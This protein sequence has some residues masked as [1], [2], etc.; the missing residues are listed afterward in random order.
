[1]AK[2]QGRDSQGRDA[3]DGVKSRDHVV[4]LQS[5]VIT[6]VARW[7]WWAL[8][9][10]F[11][12]SLALRWLGLGVFPA[13]R[14]T[15]DEYHY[16]WAGLSLLETGRPTSWSYMADEKYQ[17]AQIPWTPHPLVLVR[18]ALDHPPLFSLLC[19]LA[20]R[21]AGAHRVDVQSTGSQSA[22]F[23][24]VDMGRLRHLSLLLYAASFFLLFQCS[25]Y[26]FG[27]QAGLLACVFYGF[28]AHIVFH[29]RLLVTENLTTALMLGNILAVQLFCLGTMSRRWFCVVTVLTTACAML[30]KLVAVSQV[31]VIMGLL[32][33]YGRRRE[34]LYPLAGLL[35]GGILYAL[36]GV[37][38]GW[39][40]FLSCLRLQSGRFEGFWALQTL[41]TRMKIVHDNQLSAV[42]FAGWI[43][44]FAL[45][46]MRNVGPMASALPVYLLAFAFFAPA[47]A[48]YGWHAVPMYP[49]LCMALAVI[50]RTAFESLE[51]LLVLLF[52]V[53]L[54][55]AAF[56]V[57]NDRGLCQPAVL[58]IIF[59]MTTAAVIFSPSF[60]DRVRR[61]FLRTTLVA[62][63]VVVVANEVGI[64]WGNQ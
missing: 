37:L 51:P 3:K 32:V 48:I 58:R 31:P 2:T 44:A 8:V 41:I 27:T 55:S 25:R 35:V 10:I 20:A 15:N 62:S 22:F 4:S 49:F 11:V 50:T 59:L 53:L 9:V 42:L 45:L 57:F 24:E 33:L 63:L 5:D 7:Q 23:Y 46:M 28:T 34:L 60:A 30:C 19:G 56:D 38:E 39:Q 61:V 16:A 54:G 36:Y 12:C 40:P 17:L 14:A 18:P 47:S 64:V 1:M 6:V 43:G 29:Q 52:Y 26:A 13:P 21:L